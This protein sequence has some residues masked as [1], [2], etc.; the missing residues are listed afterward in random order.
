MTLPSLL[1]LAALAALVVSLRERWRRWEPPETRAPA[2]GLVIHGALGLAL[3]GLASTVF[4]LLGQFGPAA[5]A[6]ACGLL[7]VSLWPWTRPRHDAP[8]RSGARY[9]R[10]LLLGLGVVLLGVAL[11][12]PVHPAELGGR[13]QGTYVLR[14]RH[15]L[16]SGSIELRDP[17]LAQATADARSDPTRPGPADLLG[18]YPRPRD[19]ERGWRRGRYEAPYRPGFY[20]TDRDTGRV[21]PQFLHLHPMLLAASGAA[22]GPRGLTWVLYLQ[23]ALALLGFW[24]IARRLWPRHPHWALTACALYSF[25]PLAIWVQRTPL[26]ESLVGLLS[27]AAVLALLRARP[28]PGAQAVATLRCALLLGM[29]AW[30]RGNLWIA[31]PVVLGVLFLQT[32]PRRDRRA[33]AA[34]VGLAITSLVVHAGSSFPYLHDEFRR[35]LALRD[36]LPPQSIAAAALACALLWYLVDA[37]LAPRL[38]RVPSL[39]RAR[40]GIVRAL[41][42]LWLSASFAAVGYYLLHRAA[43]GS[44]PPFSR[45]DPAAPLL[46]LPFLILAGLGLIRACWRWRPSDARAHLW[47]LAALSLPVIALLVYARRNLPHRALYY[48]GRYLVPELLPVACALV[49]CALAGLHDG[50]RRLQARWLP[51]RAAIATCVTALATIGA[52]LHTSAALVL[53]PPTRM[54]EFAGADAL[55]TWLDEHVPD[56]A[57]VIAGGEGWHHSHTYN[58]VGGALAI[59]RGRAVLPYHSQEAAYAALH[60]LLIARPDHAGEDAPPV[61][62]L[63]NEATHNYRPRSPEGAAGPRTAAFDSLLPAPLRAASIELL[64]LFVDRLTP[65]DDELPIQVTRSELR[66]ALIRVTVDADAARVVGRWRFTGGAI[67]GPPG[68]ELAG[69]FWREGQLCLRKK[70]PLTIRFTDALDDRLR[71]AL[72]GGALVLVAAPG[73]ARRNPTWRIKLDGRRLEPRMPAPPRPRPRDTLG[74][75]TLDERPRELT[76]RGGPRRD[77]DVTCRRGGLYELRLLPAPTIDARAPERPIHALSFGPAADLGHPLEPTRWVQGRA[78]SRYRAGTRPRAPVRSLSLVLRANES[79]HF[80]PYSLPIDPARAPSP[81]GV[82]LDLLVTLKETQLSPDARLVVTID[83]IERARLDP[84]DRGGTW[85]APPVTLRVTRPVARVSLQLVEP[86]RGGARALVR[87]VAFVRRDPVVR[88]QLVSK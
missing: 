43:A 70:I 29:T 33:S 45:L 53:H 66:M 56:D 6:L 8:P 86:A 82:P 38:W 11:R 10:H 30:V 58:Q 49:T 80:A 57:V 3:V 5:L 41:P 14:A 23:A 85:I 28:E 72:V 69:D 87:D 40:A 65:V 67:E 75:F 18:L 60:E 24:A 61:Y 46:G 15:A 63:V 50:L 21:V 59:G 25:S 22:F 55:L 54:T 27:I 17:V 32:G 52:L 16:R 84:P 44:A 7:A 4:G 88:S 2:E 51:G 78:L 9:D 68:L 26:T 73:T 76:L 1:L 83:D 19:V 20:I 13:D 64:E 47:L 62:L 48:Y 74:P 36:G 81:E 39:A 71:E 37:A 42:W 12:I 79:L 35:Q 34:L 31:L 77:H